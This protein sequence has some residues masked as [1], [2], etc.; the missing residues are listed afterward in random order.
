MSQPESG[1]MGMAREGGGV[2][3]LRPAALPTVVM[4][5]GGGMV[6]GGPKLTVGSVLQALR[7]WWKMCAP[8]GVL[9]AGIAAAAVWASFEPVYRATASLVISDQSPYLAYAPTGPQT[10]F[11]RTE[12]EKIRH[13]LVVSEAI[14][15]PKIAQLGDLK[16]QESP[17]EW[18]SSKITVK[19]VGQ[20][21]MYEVSFESPDAAGAAAIVNA[22]LEA[23]MSRQQS[24]AMEQNRNMITL[25]EREGDLRQSEVMQLRTEL[26]LLKREAAG[27]DAVFAGS[28]K[29]E[30]VLTQ[31]PVGR[32]MDSLTE[33][34]VQRRVLELSREALK[35]L[36]AKKQF[37]V[38]PPMIDQAVDADSEVMALRGALDAK[39]V[40][41]AT[42]K[43][44]QALVEAEQAKLAAKREGEIQ[45]LGKQL[46]ARRADLRA[47]KAKELTEKVASEQQGKLASLGAQIE[48]QQLVEGLLKEQIGEERKRMEASGE[49][50]LDLE[51]KEAALE[52]AEDVY[53]RLHERAEQLKIET[54]APGR[55]T[56]FQKATVPMTPVEPVPYAM[57]GAAGAGSF[58][59]PFVLA[60][61]W[62]RKTR[63]IA[64][65]E[66]I[67]EE[68]HLPVV[69]E[70]T[71]LPVKPAG[72]RRKSS[73]RYERERGMFEESVD[74]VRT[75]LLLSQG[76]EKLQVIAVASAIS[77]EGKTSLASHLAVSLA[78]SSPEAVLLIDAD[79]RSPDI[80]EL[81]EIAA[82]PGLA[83]VLD[84]RRTLGEAVVETWTKNLHV[85]PAGELTKSPHVLLGNG[86]LKALLSEARLTYR[87]IIVDAPPVLPVSDALLIAR[88]AD[89][90]LISTMRDVTRGPQVK[91]ACERLVAAG[92]RLVGAVLSGVPARKYV[93]RYGSGSYEYYRARGEAAEE[94]KPNG[95]SE[96]AGGEERG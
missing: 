44:D 20:S 93:S 49:Q 70:I 79:M 26:R 53:D 14:S 7:R 89:G 39:R 10:R 33:T 94:A 13:P 1:G 6:V 21:E 65:R 25:L 71:M 85:L 3:A 42:E 52:R 76:L 56:V 75:S 58:C 69:G 67:Q 73:E 46:E 54:R 82:Q 16:K 88:I 78:R 87:Y 29:K 31:T 64:E 86:A 57:L 96:G 72:S 95:Q 55:V 11:Q 37:E 22:V 5:G 43:A 47:V 51:F 12:V 59:L 23:Y 62:D 40:T 77:R 45:S 41:L 27:K 4:G 8:V 68:I 60:L 28:K 36:I 50:S 17:I 15:D 30:V 35:Q 24:E 81:F 90:T 2:P 84:G 92:A 66:E 61:F 63:R 74:Y 38:T 19:A 18:L 32:L 83:E 91:L 80:H 34:E 9:L 48:Q